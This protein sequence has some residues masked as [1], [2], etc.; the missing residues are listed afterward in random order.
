MRLFFAIDLPEELKFQL[1]KLYEKRV[2]IEGVNAVVKE[3]LHITLKFLGE[4]KEVLLP[5]LIARA[6]SVA[7]G[8]ESFTVRVSKTGVFPNTKNPRVVWIGIEDD[9]A[10]KELALSLESSLENLGIPREDREFKSHITIARVKIPSKGRE[11]YEFLRARFSELLKQD[12]EFSNSLGIE[13]REFVLM[14]STLTPKGAVY[15]V[16]NRFPFSR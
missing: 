8:R 13:V 12:T 5:E 11:F 10:I 4:V 7:E 9:R 1:A 3:N 2:H 15:R 16:L 6:S 14:E